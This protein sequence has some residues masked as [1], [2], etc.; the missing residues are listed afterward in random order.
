MNDSNNRITLDI[1]SVQ[2]QVALHVKQ[3][4][5][6]R[7]IYI[8]LTDGGQPYT[9]GEK[10][11]AVFE[12]KK[13]DGKTIG[14]NCSIKN[15]AI[16][17]RITEETVT[18]PGVVNCEVSLYDIDGGLI[19]SPRFALVVDKRVTGDKF[20][21]SDEFGSL[22]EVLAAASTAENER[23]ENEEE[24][25]NLW[26]RRFDSPNVWE[27]ETGVYRVTGLVKAERDG[28]AFVV[29]NDS[30]LWVSNNGG[31][32]VFGLA[33]ALGGPG[34]LPYEILFGR[35]DG[36]TC[37]WYGIESERAKVQKLDSGATHEGYPSPKAVYDLVNDFSNQAEKKAN[38]VT[39]IGSTATDEQYPS[40]K[41]VYD[42]VKNESLREESFGGIFSVED[43][44]RKTENVEARSQT[45]TS[46]IVGITTYM[47]KDIMFGQNDFVSKMVM[48]QW[49]MEGTGLEDDLVVEF[50]N[51]S[52]TTG[53]EGSTL[54]KSVESPT[55]ANGVGTYQV[56]LDMR[57]DDLSELD[58]EFILGIRSKGLNRLM[59]G[60]GTDKNI[61]YTGN[62]TANPDG[63]LKYSGYYL[64]NSSSFYFKSIDAQYNTLKYSS[65]IIEFV[66]EGGLRKIDY[67]KIAAGLKE[68]EKTLLRLP[69]KFDLVVGDTFELFYKG[70][71]EVIDCKYYDFEIDFPV[72]VKPI[73]KAYKRKYVVT[74]TVNDV[75]EKTMIVSIRKNDGELIESS[76]VL[77]NIVEKPASPV[78]NKI[79][80]C[81][82]DSL[83]Q[84]GRWQA[85]L[86]RRLTTND[87]TPTG[88]GLSNIQF[89]GSK[90]YNSTKYEGYGGWSFAN[91]LSES[92]SNGF[93]NIFGDF[94]KTEDD[95]HSVYKDINGVKWKLET[96]GSAKMKIIRVDA[97]GVLPSSGTLFWV[98]GGSNTEDIVYTSSEQAAGNPF[99]NENLSKNDFT[100][101]AKKMGVN[102]IDYVYILLGWNSTFEN[103]DTYIA[104]CETFID[105]I[106]DDF[107]NCRIGLIG[108]QVP[109]ADGFAHNYGTSWKFREK[110][111]F[112][113]DLQRWYIELSQKTKYRGK[114][115]YINFSGQFDTENC[116]PSQE[117]K[118]NARSEKTER[119][120]TN[121]VHPSIEG[122]MQ[123]ADVVYRN[124]CSKL[125]GDRNGG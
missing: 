48:P 27:L 76:E 12:A 73:G 89:I 103:K 57:K 90:E 98:S 71:A 30:L 53:V 32:V 87:G 52:H 54:I 58:E 42:F 119:I 7:V 25:Y 116:M 15:N 115:D 45:V 96:L 47:T 112:V 121:G 55:L 50:R 75:G 69:E 78:S 82:G 86:N 118:V 84:G 46:T 124:L 44:C 108:L 101:Y 68:L 77:L 29:E 2:S 97:S 59:I 120:Q 107:P 94:D 36:E 20:T 72:G 63:K 22:C 41:A 43:V 9:I 10:C 5:T 80:L 31:S 17:Y 37:E 93:M 111:Q 106:L 21:S 61:V 66:T 85:E 122:Y 99:W 18:A 28:T 13:P 49:V 14:N 88:I 114:V 64:K 56:R 92:S 8:T 102:T 60:Y 117:I 113:F 51:P 34:E 65:P 109:S 11:Y 70:I 39:E 23:K 91:Y 40:T 95:Q 67:T 26:N 123:L 38:K 62:H 24:R 35:T 110:L 79:L 4:D 104:K 1:T 6:S 81:I 33:L 100:E 16:V 105:N 125:Q 74:P 3:L 83:S 19:T